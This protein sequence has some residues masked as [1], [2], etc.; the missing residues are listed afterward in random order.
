[1][2]APIAAGGLAVSMLAA[3]PAAADGSDGADGTILADLAAVSTRAADAKSPAVQQGR[4]VAQGGFGAAS[5]TRPIRRTAT[6]TDF[7]SDPPPPANAAQRLTRVVATQDL[8]KGEFVA[9][10]TFASAPSGAADNAI[11]AVYFGEYVDGY[12]TS[13]ISILG[14]TH[15]SG[16]GGVF[17]SDGANLAVKRSRSGETVTLRSS[18]L[19]ARVKA[20]E[21]ECMLAAVFVDDPDVPVHKTTAPRLSDVHPPE[22]L[23]FTITPGDPVQGNYAG[24]VTRIRLEVRN[25]SRTPATGVRLRA[26]GKSMKIGKPV[27][28]LGRV[29]GRTTKHGIIYNVRLQGAKPRKL[30]FRVTAGGRTF[31][32][33]ITIARKPAPRRLPS[34]VGRYF[35]GHGPA[36]ADTGWDTRAAYFVNNRFVY[37]GF[38]QGGQRPA[39]RQATKLCKRYAYNARTGRLKI[40]KAK[41]VAI[42]SEGF[43][44][45]NGRYYPTTLAKKGQRFS[46][47]L[48]RHD[49]HGNCLVFCNTR[50]EWL[51]FNKNGRFVLSSMSIGSW[52]VPGSGGQWSTIP[53]DEKGTYQVIARGRVQLNFA[54][55]KKQRHTL[56]IDH[57]IRNKPSPGGAGLILGDRN[58]YLDD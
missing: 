9:Q 22:P 27:R 46:V 24:K 32:R 37:L 26:I 38:P 29:D 58:F 4:Q 11:V 2:A 54:S 17:Q 28:N 36:S 53:P 35:W 55:G 23:K 44:F 12:C 51:Q 45:R 41:P 16:T 19:P 56:A 48:K 50:T 10:A 15:G 8:Q 40:A 6:V 43:G 47:N 25:E 20:A 33:A 31:N 34:L 18:A 42:T 49:F 13:R 30:I 57:D 7:E 14:E 3:V 52:G 21:P 1:M 5:T 39:C